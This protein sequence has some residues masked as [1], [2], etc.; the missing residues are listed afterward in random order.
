MKAEASDPA[1]LLQ[2]AL[3]SLETIFGLETAS[4]ERELLSWHLHDWQRDPYSLGAYSY[5]PV[6]ALDSSEHMTEPAED[7]LYLAGEHTDVSGHWGTVHGALRSGLRAA[8][9]I[10]AAE[11]R[12]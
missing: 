2:S 11:G 8:R 12:S 6:G 4:L 7:T 10:L 9:Q 1:K 5:A 3:R